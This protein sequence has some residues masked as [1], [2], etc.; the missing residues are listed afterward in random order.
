MNDNPDT[1][2][3]AEPDSGALQAAEVNAMQSRQAAEAAA[4]QIVTLCAHVG[5]L[6]I[7]VARCCHIIRDAYP[8]RG[9]FDRF[10]ET[11]GFKNPLFP[12]PAAAWDAANNWVGLQQDRRFRDLTR[13]APEEALTLTRVFTATMAADGQT[14]TAAD[15]DENETTVNE[16]LAMPP[17]KRKGWMRQTRAALRAARQKRNPDDVA[18]IE[19]LEVTNKA[20]AAQAAE[21][22][23][24][25][26]QQR[27][28]AVDRMRAC[29]N[30]LADALLEAAQLGAQN[31]SRHQRNH[32]LQSMDLTNGLMDKDFVHELW[33]A[34][35]S[36][37]QRR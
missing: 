4:A 6:A 1:L 31:Y 20:L 17:R 33:M 11:K 16:V 34:R 12:S 28:A 2:I 18:R 14:L 25:A 27:K 13:V 19:E 37:A 22:E 26:A 3:P 32:L 10:I 30:A 21:T 29:A 15:L 36:E 9:A 5:L 23:K 8:D 24:S 7:R 35:E